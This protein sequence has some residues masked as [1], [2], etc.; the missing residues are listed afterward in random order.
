MCTAPIRDV[1]KNYRCAPTMTDFCNCVPSLRSY[2]KPGPVLW[3][4]GFLFFFLLFFSFPFSILLW[5]QIAVPYMPTYIPQTIQRRLP[6][7]STLESQA[8]LPCSLGFEVCQK[9]EISAWPRGL[10]TLLQAATS[11]PCTVGGA[12][13]MTTQLVVTEAISC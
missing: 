2:P 7:F 1:F 6:T 5:K 4:K 3:D 10:G 8:I 11:P 12:L 9:E 13:Q